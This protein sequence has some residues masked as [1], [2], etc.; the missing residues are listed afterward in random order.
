[1]RNLR[2]IGG[3]A[4]TAVV[5]GGVVWF[6]KPDAEV[7]QPSSSGE[8][9]SAPAAHRRN[10]RAAQVCVLA[11]HVR[12]AYALTTRTQATVDAHAAGAGQASFATRN[13][14]VFHSTL[15]LEAQRAVDDGTIMLGR[16]V[17]LDS[18]T[19]L[20]APGIGDT[21][22]LFRLSSTCETVGFARHRS[23]PL[24]AARAQ[25]ATLAQL[26]FRV[27]HA[28][29]E[30]ANAENSLGPFSA[31][32]AREGE[33]VQRRIVAYERAWG[34]AQ[35]PSVTDS[36]LAV[37]L[38]AEPWFESMTGNEVVS[39]GVFASASA[40]LKVARA[41]VDVSVLSEHPRDESEYIWENLLPRIVLPPTAAKERS[42]Q[43]RAAMAALVDKP[44]EQAVRE[45]AAKVVTEP[46]VDAKWRGLAR[47]FEVHPEHVR[48]F[49]GSMQRPDFP[50]E[51]KALG[52]VAVGHAQATEARDVLLAV[53]DDVAADP[54]DRVRATL[55]LIGRDDVGAE[56]AKQLHR[57]SSALLTEP[58]TAR[59]FYG[60]N[61]LLALGMFSALRQNQDAAVAAEAR[62]SISEALTAS[63]LTA[64][65]DDPLPAA[66]G[67][68]G[69][70]GDP[71][72]LPTIIGLSKHPS[73]DV[74]AQ[75]PQAMRRLRQE[76]VAA[77][78]LDWLQRETSPEV[79]KELY[80][81]IQHQLLDEQTVASEA[82]LR[83]AAKDLSAQP[84]LLTR[85]PLVRILGPTASTYE[86]VRQTLVAQAVK[87]VGTPSGLY[88]VIAQYVPGDEVS[89]ALAPRLAP[90]PRTPPLGTNSTTGVAP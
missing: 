24:G 83:Q 44:F 9:T 13:T 20:T 36:F 25:Q 77:F 80:S 47:Y 50:G 69:N 67:A 21:A 10:A 40:E 52:F 31:V 28:A 70:L 64:G 7:T 46:N 39:S 37:Q 68:M 81:V 61:A 33:V 11:P 34:S 3:A 60:R 90:L 73:P 29:S 26:W 59:G 19:S 18:T 65:A 49:V 45:F 22:F 76:Q 62:A 74:R 35:V 56:L 43:E 1:M 66:L 42:P 79:K 6:G 89:A 30:P 57:D 48:S 84:L 86:F 72:D 17:G 8:V 16:L 53:R 2:F 75:V 58:K 87:E 23:A 78:T 15:Q 32:L 55:A 71:A 51:L 5:L 41:T 27:P 14:G 82:L 4:L 38:G 88:S 12:L 85:Q 63:E 54:Y